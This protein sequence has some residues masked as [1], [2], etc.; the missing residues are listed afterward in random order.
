[1]VPTMTDK[2]EF[3][4]AQDMPATIQIRQKD[5]SFKVE[6]LDAVL[7]R[8]SAQLE[9]ATLDSLSSA[10]AD[11][12][13]DLDPAFD[14]SAIADLVSKLENVELTNPRSHGPSAEVDNLIRYDQFVRGSNLTVTSSE[15]DRSGEQ[16]TADYLSTLTGRRKYWAQKMLRA[17]IEVGKIHVMHETT[18]FYSL[19]RVERLR[20]TAEN[21]RGRPVYRS[22]P[23]EVVKEEEEDEEMEIDG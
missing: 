7:S 3:T 4:N 20:K 11:P 16:A 19:S 13:G 6:D 9:G 8:I 1:M 18:D 12:A 5:G 14:A 21:Y 10:L 17:G 15:Q 23:L 22:E 2:N